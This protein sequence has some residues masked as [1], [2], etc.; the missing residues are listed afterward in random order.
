[1]NSHSK[2]AGKLSVR[3]MCLLALMGAMMFASQVAMASLPNIHIVA[4][5]IIITA[6]AFSWRALYSVAVFVLLE[7]LIRRSVPNTRNQMLLRERLY[8]IAENPCVRYGVT[9]LSN[10]G[11]KKRSLLPVGCSVSDLL[12]FAS[13]LA[14]HHADMLKTSAPLQAF[15]GTLLAKGFDLEDLYP[16][17]RQAAGF[18]LDGISFDRAA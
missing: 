5:L 1:M 4:F 15:S 14:T 6:L 12:N 17:S 9:D 8:E 18:Y 13:E 11:V 16:S 7:G 3:D 10:I 2:R